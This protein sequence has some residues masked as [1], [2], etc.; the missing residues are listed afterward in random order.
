L[1]VLVDVDDPL[2]LCVSD[3]TTVRDH[4]CVEFPSNGGDVC[5]RSGQGRP[6]RTEL[7]GD[8]RRGDS[9]FLVDDDPRP[10]R[11]SSI[12]SV[13]IDSTALSNPSASPSPNQPAPAGTVPAL[14]LHART[15][16]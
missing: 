9:E 3:G 12:L 7:A 15:P 1:S 8:F 6:F 11:G 2:R 16:R 13:V 14:V 10:S 5:V 4:W